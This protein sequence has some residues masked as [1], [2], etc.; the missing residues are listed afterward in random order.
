[1]QIQMTCIYHRARHKCRRTSCASI[2]GHR[3][4]QLLRLLD[5]I[6]FAT[7][8]LPPV[9]DVAAELDVSLRRRQYRS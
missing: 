8:M 4:A 5:K 9:V 1:M 6:I 3:I 7:A 2:A